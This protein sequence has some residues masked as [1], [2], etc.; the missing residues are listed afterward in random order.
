MDSQT[1]GT[2]IVI[3]TANSTTKEG[4]KSLRMGDAPEI[5]ALDLTA[6]G[7]GHLLP[8]ISGEGGGNMVTSNTLPSFWIVHPIARFFEALSGNEAR[9]VIRWL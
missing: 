4:S 2:G 9:G 5:H 8:G 3:V 1:K 7:T 6:K